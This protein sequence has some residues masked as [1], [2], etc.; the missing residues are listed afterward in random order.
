[1]ELNYYFA[2]MELNCWNEGSTVYHQIVTHFNA[3]KRFAE[4][5]GKKSLKISEL[6]QQ[7]DFSRYG[8]SGFL[9]G[10]KCEGN[11]HSTNPKPSTVEC[12]F[13]LMKYS[14]LNKAEY[15]VFS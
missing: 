2:F 11:V 1:M 10:A 14:T 6:K 9:V 3:V 13:T 4:S 15:Q 7:Y 8:F 5:A 12:G